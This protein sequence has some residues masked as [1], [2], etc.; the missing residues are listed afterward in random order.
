MTNADQKSPDHEANIRSADQRATAVVAVATVTASLALAGA[1]IVVDTGKLTQPSGVREW[2]TG[3]L[4]GAVAAF[5]VSALFAA[6]GHSKRWDPEA[7]EQAD[8][9]DTSWRR[10]FKKEVA[11]AKQLSKSKH[12]RVT[13]SMYGLLVGMLFLVGVTIASYVATG[14]PPPPAR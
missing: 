13:K 9:T 5:T 2:L 3:L 1:T 4:I 14:A 11:D 7:T 6:V 10:R 8:T 12:D